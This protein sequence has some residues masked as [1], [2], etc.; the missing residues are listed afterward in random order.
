[1]EESLRLRTALK[2]SGAAVFAV[3][4]Q[5]KLRLYLNEA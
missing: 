2:P 3:R 1:M 4:L 5:E